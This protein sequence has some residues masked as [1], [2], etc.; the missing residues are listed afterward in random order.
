MSASSIRRTAAELRK[1]AER[2]LQLAAEKELEIEFIEGWGREAQTRCDPA[3]LARLIYRSRIERAAYF[4]AG[5]LG[6]PGWDMLLDLFIARSA[7]KDVPATSLCLA[8]RVAQTTGLRW[9]A[10]LERAGLIER[11]ADSS[12]GR[13]SNVRMTAEAAKQMHTYLK[14]HLNAYLAVP[15]LKLVGRGG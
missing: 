13:V 3:H 7:G 4:D 10:N 12:D 1:I 9:I 11:V 14:R 8:A 5:L 15:D 2:L 6:E